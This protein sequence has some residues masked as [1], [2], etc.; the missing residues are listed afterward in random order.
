MWV[1]SDSFSDCT[2]FYPFL[3]CVV[4]ACSIWAEAKPLQEEKEIF[5]NNFLKS[6]KWR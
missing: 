2:C 3:F 6:Q 1:T 5:Q 4:S